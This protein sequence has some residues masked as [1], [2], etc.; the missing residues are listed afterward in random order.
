[1]KLSM[2]LKT[3]YYLFEIKFI[4]L[5]VPVADNDTSVYTMDS[6][7][8]V[9]PHPEVSMWLQVED[10]NSSQHNEL[11]S[12][13]SNQYNITAPKPTSSIIINNNSTIQPTSIGTAA[14]NNLN[15][16]YSSSLTERSNN[17]NIQPSPT[18]NTTSMSSFGSSSPPARIN[19]FSLEPPPTPRNTI[20]L[21]MLTLLKGSNMS[22]HKQDIIISDKLLLFDFHAL[23]KQMEESVKK[24]YQN[25]ENT[26]TTIPISELISCTQTEKDIK[27]DISRY[28]GQCC[29]NGDSLED[30]LKE[31]YTES[32]KTIMD[33]DFFRNFL[34]NSQTKTLMQRIDYY[35]NLRDKL[36]RVKHIGPY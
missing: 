31:N 21:L 28:V 11:S 20:R 25:L 34:Q 1:M 27:K 5:E 15:T 14:N 12:A 26:N 17:T 2:I 9:Y 29:G 19:N 13:M 10:I 24:C 3:Q 33:Y 8:G 30:I 7:H 4:S 22:Y 16:T 18:T 35:N 6:P 23:L 36:F 32:G